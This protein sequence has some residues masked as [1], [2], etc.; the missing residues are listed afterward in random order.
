ME[1]GS[2]LAAPRFVTLSA[3]F[4]K[5]NKKENTKQIPQLLLN[6]VEALIS[7][8]GAC[9]QILPP[10]NFQIRMLRT[11]KREESGASSPVQLN[12]V[13]AL[14]LGGGARPQHLQLRGFQNRDQRSN[15]GG[16]QGPVQLNNSRSK[17]TNQIV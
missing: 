13:E 15:K 5:S 7:G 6:N 14:I 4:K 12:N 9:P 8:G 16:E 11:Y 17:L 2:L 10:R 1:R 3:S